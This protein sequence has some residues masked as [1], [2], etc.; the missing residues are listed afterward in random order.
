MRKKEWKRNIIKIK[1]KWRKRY[2]VLKFNC[3]ND[4]IHW[5]VPLLVSYLPSPTLLALLGAREK[6]A[7]TTSHVPLPRMLPPPIPPRLPPPIAHSSSRSLLRLLH[8]T[9]S[10]GL[11]SSRGIRKDKGIVRGLKHVVQ[12]VNR[13]QRS[14][15]LVQSFCRECE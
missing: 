3:L 2:T 6:W 9:L 14:E 13:I 10:Q 4:N 15:G 7:S 1:E 5:K 11:S 12:L 8:T